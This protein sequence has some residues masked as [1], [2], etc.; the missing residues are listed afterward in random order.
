MAGSEQ[1]RQ[2]AA[3]SESACPIYPPTPPPVTVSI[4]VM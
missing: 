3:R 4:S 1:G 2:Q